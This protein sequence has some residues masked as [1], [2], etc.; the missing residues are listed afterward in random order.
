MGGRDE[1]GV[2]G[3]DG[4]VVG[5]EEFVGDGGLPEGGP[6]FEIVGV[7]GAV[8]RAT[9]GKGVEASVSGITEGSEHAGDVFE[10][11]LFGA[12]FGER[13]RGFAFE[14]E[15]D[16]V[17]AGAEELAEVVVAV[18]ADALAGG[19]GGG[20]GDG[21]GAGV[22]FEATGEDEGCIVGGGFGDLGD[23][24]FEGGEGCGELGVDAV[25]FGYEVGGGEALCAEGWV[26]GCGVEGEVHLG[27]ATA[28]EGCG[29]EVE[30][31]VLVEE[32]G[33]SLWLLGRN[34]GVSSLS[35]ER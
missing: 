13:A 28:K 26:I 33:W 27:C 9:L 15:D 11:R 4:G 34:A 3:V 30:G 19:V 21:S 18:D 22:E 20:R 7:L 2:L 12:S 10:G 17:F 32:G 25:G 8:G 14:V 1:I 23:I 16:D 6:G 35:R 31:G 5:V 29:V 24:A